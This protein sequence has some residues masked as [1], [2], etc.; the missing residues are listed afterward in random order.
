MGCRASV[1]NLFD[2]RDQFYGRQF[3]P[4]TRLGW[5][6][7][8]GFWMIQV[9]YLCCALYFIIISLC[10]IMNYTLHHNAESVGALN[11]FS[12]NQTV[13]LGVMGER[14]GANI[15]VKLRLLSRCSSPAV[16]SGS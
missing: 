6:G 13:H 14:W 3:F 7:R 10:Y 15:D 4:P 8:D 2:T 11:L 12:C 1:P 9:H 5:W 16:Q